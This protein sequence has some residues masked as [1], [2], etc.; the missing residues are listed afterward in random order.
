MINAILLLFSPGPTWKRLASANRPAW[1]VFL[2]SFLPVLLISCGLQAWVL[3]KYGTHNSAVQRTQQV[4]E[5]LATR[6]ATTQFVMG[7]VSLVPFESRKLA[8]EKSRNP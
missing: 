6:Y 7:L 4:S 2:L 5:I 8:G 1:V 3:W